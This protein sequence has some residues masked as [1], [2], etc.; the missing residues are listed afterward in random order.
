MFDV[1][2]FA[3]EWASD[4]HV[5]TFAKTEWTI[6]GLIAK[7]S[8][9]WMFGDPGCYK[10]FA[11]LDMVGCVGANKQWHGRDV[12]PGPV[13]FLAGEGGKD[14]HVRRM[15]WE[16]ANET[17]TAIK[18]ISGVPQLDAISSDF[19]LNLHDDFSKDIWKKSIQKRESECSTKSYQKLI[20]QDEA[21]KTFDQLYELKRKPAP[22]MTP[23]AVFCIDT[24][25]TVCADDTKESVSR[26][27]ANLR[28]L[29][30]KFPETAILVIDHTTKSGDSFMGSQAKLGN[31]D[32]FVE[33]ERKGDVVTLISRK[34]KFTAPPDPIALAVKLQ[35]IGVHDTKG[36]EL[37]SLVC[38]DGERQKRIAEL[39]GGDTHAGYI[40][41]Q[42]SANAGTIGRAELLEGFFSSRCKGLK[43]DSAKRAFRRALNELEEAELIQI[44]D[45]AGTVTMT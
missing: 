17:R 44:D 27:F 29:V 21:N 24:F 13:Y 33:A 41:G 37:G 45:D 31:S 39:V 30:R 25:S 20:T 15:A 16:K 4:S 12:S 10:T 3:D 8:I 40:L 19:L 1:S 42:L 38:I 2:I 6:D 34:H 43:A 35:P 9:N 11:A 5:D 18:I 22:K 26:F 7:G 28:K 36:R 32:W 23:P 14:L